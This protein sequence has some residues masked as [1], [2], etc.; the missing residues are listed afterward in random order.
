MPADISNFDVEL[1]KE[2]DKEILRVFTFL[3]NNRFFRAN[4]EYDIIKRIK[5]SDTYNSL[6]Y[7]DLR[8]EFGL[9][10]PGRDLD[11]VL[12]DLID[13]RNI[14]INVGKTDNA[15][16]RVDINTGFFI[17]DSGVYLSDGGLVDWLNWL[18]YRG[19]DI[20]VADHSILYSRDAGREFPTSRSGQAIMIP[21]GSYSVPPE[22]AGTEND[23]WLTK[24]M[25]G[26][27]D[28]IFELIKREI[29]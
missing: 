12:R 26:I 21:L 2:L 14:E 15:F 1:Q 6:L 18:L 13:P 23:N 17:S 25:D 11:G 22:Y 9:E 10:F 20:V 4:I 16:I 27:Q 3:Q 29:Q 8:A 28:Y 24:A 7:G 19:T 5:E